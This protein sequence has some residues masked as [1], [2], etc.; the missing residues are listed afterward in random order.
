MN[1]RGH[2]ELSPLL[3]GG[4]RE[5]V[6]LKLCPADGAVDA[7]VLRAEIAS[8]IDQSLTIEGH[9]GFDEAHLPHTSVAE[10]MATI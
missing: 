8:A 1:A 4:A 9:Q 5:L 3:F 10:W 7:A 2:D 6:N